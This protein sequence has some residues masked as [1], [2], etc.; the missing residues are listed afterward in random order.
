RRLDCGSIKKFVGGGLSRGAPVGHVW[1]IFYRRNS[2][3]FVDMENESSVQP[4]KNGAPGRS[5]SIFKNVA[6]RS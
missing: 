1:D 3:K 4:L 6:S 2:P 5:S